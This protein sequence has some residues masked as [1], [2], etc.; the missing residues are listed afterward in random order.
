MRAI[1]LRHGTKPDLS[2]NP[3]TGIDEF[4]DALRGTA[5]LPARHD[6]IANEIIVVLYPPN[7]SP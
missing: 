1:R 5:M 3:V 2:I 6:E 4:I 7:S